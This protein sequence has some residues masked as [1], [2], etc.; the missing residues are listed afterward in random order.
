MEKI[1]EDAPVITSCTYDEVSDQGHTSISKL[2]ESESGQM[3]LEKV[4]WTIL[5]YIYH[6][7]AKKS[8]KKLNRPNS[9]FLQGDASQLR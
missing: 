8:T 3:V 1:V 5:V 2:E 6:K 4:K 7:H 9:L